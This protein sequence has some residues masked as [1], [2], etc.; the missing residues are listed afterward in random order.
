MEG[1]HRWGSREE[2]SRAPKGRTIA[3]ERGVEKQSTGGVGGGSGAKRRA[4]AEAVAQY[5]EQRGE[6]EQR[7]EGGSVGA[8]WGVVYL[9]SAA[10]IAGQP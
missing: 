3:R 8:E 7:G 9:D 2:R 1:R 4:R 6:R 5:G 10:K